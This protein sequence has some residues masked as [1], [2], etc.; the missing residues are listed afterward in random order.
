MT[1]EPNVLDISSDLTL[2]G[3]SWSSIFAG[4]AAA[5]ALSLIL[6]ILGVGLGFPA[7]SPWANTGVSTST[8]GV[9]TILWLTFTQIAASAVGGYLSGRLRIKWP[10]VHT[11]EVYFRDTAHGF[12][13]WSLASLAT[14]ALLGTVVGNVVSSGV[15]T[16]ASQKTMVGMESMLEETTGAKHTA[17]TMPTNLYME[18]I[19]SGDAELDYRV[20][21][22]FRSDHQVIE[23]TPNSFSDFSATLLE[24]RRI[25]AN[26]LRMNGLPIEDQQYLTQVIANDLGITPTDAGK[27]VSEVFDKAHTAFVNREQTS[28]Q[29]AENARKAAAYSA[30]WMFVAL[31]SGAFVAS[32]AATFGGKQRDRVS[33]KSDIGL[34]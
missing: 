22:L 25:F 12:L 17:P 32:L 31:L 5:A 20:D 24:A 21:S 4:A 33:Q 11:D 27:R 1:T 30:L 26:G 6:L 2:S 29:T 19:F 28:K 15:A 8:L 10:T 7:I 16:A 34:A 3:I 13:V 9:A 18:S 14:A 23:T